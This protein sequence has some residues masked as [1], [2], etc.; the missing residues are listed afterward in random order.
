[1]GEKTL[2]RYN[3][4]SY[5][6]IKSIQTVYEISTSNIFLEHIVYKRWFFCNVS[7]LINR[8]KDNRFVHIFED[9]M[10]LSTVSNSGDINFKSFKTP[11][12]MITILHNISWIF[13]QP[14]CYYTF[15]HRQFLLHSSIMCVFYNHVTAECR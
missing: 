8:Q 12:Q 13:T 6:K 11:E 15:T 2:I 10:I 3:P 14:E 9:T 7:T 4:V 1:M 5:K